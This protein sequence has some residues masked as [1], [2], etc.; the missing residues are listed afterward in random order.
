[1]RLLKATLIMVFWMT[2]IGASFAMFRGDGA[3]T[4]HSLVVGLA[5]TIV[6]GLPYLTISL[7]KRLNNRQE[8][9]K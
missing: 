3:A 8:V 2:A 4:V 5:L 7:I 1:M 6:V 9:S